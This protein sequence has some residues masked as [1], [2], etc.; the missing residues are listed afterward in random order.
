MVVP[1]QAV[2]S[3]L[4]AV[5]ENNPCVCINAP[6]PEQGE[7]DREEGLTTA[8]TTTSESRPIVTT[9]G[10]ESVLATS[11]EE[12]PTN[13]ETIT[14]A[15][16]QSC[17]PN[18]LTNRSGC[19][20][21]MMT[22]S[23]DAVVPKQPTEKDE[24]STQAS[25]KKPKIQEGTA[26]QNTAKNKT[27]AVEGTLQKLSKR[28]LRN[29]FSKRRVCRKRQEAR[30][31]GFII[32]FGRRKRKTMPSAEEVP[33]CKEDSKV[34]PVSPLSS[35]Y[36]K[37]GPHRNTSDNSTAIENLQSDSKV[38]QNPT[39]STME[40]NK[41]TPD[42]SIPEST[43]PAALA[44]AS[45]SVSQGSQ[46]RYTERLA[47]LQPASDEDQDREFDGDRKGIPYT[48]RLLGPMQPEAVMCDDRNESIELCESREFD[49]VGTR[50]DPLLNT[51]IAVNDDDDASST[52]ED[53]KSTGIVEYDE[54]VS[55]THLT[56][57]TKA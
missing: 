24:S 11:T 9:I 53:L 22:A 43:R 39:D 3:F 46:D 32:L 56:L 41:T 12:E 47:D 51:T 38:S 5:E 48:T 2:N 42:H 18:D 26:T 33:V 20:D 54:T 55:Y 52:Q 10:D 8:S 57:P 34:V 6:V 25:I 19:A 28:R 31:S 17:Q 21:A 45:T 30:G 35:S 14:K 16:V 15:L 23:L 13:N 50:D 37:L 29:P 4:Q 27:L 44:S 1:H 36:P 49:T 40:Q 7:E